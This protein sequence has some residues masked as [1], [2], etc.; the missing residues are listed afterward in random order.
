MLTIDYGAHSSGTLPIL[1]PTCVN[2]IRKGIF[3][4]HVLKE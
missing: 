1:M 4:S 2:L 3:S